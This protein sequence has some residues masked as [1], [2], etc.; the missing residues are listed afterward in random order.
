MST[1]E[2][3]RND[4]KGRCVELFTKNANTKGAPDPKKVAEEIKKNTKKR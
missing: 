3:K 1:N 2:N 4:I